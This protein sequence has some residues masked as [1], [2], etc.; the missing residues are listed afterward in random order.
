MPADP[1]P[2]KGAY[3]RRRKREKKTAL[4]L[5]NYGSEAYVQAIHAEGCAV[6]NH[7]PMLSAKQA[8]WISGDG[9]STCDGVMEAAHAVKK[10]RSGSRGW[11]DLACLCTQHHGEQ[12]GAEKSFEEKYQIGM[13]PLADR[14]VTKHGHLVTAA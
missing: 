6:W 13:K 9:I 8:G 12:E 14:M 11:R 7:S 5:R 1:K 2:K 10:T 3:A 4:W